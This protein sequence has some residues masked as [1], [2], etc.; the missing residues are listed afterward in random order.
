MG[1]V[2]CPDAILLRPTGCLHP[3]WSV[4]TVGCTTERIADHRL[5]S[6]L[7]RHGNRSG[8]CDLGSPTGN[9]HPRNKQTIG[10]RMVAAAAALVYGDRNIVY[11][12]PTATA[13]R[14]ITPPPA[15]SVRVE[16]AFVQESPLQA[17]PNRCPAELLGTS[18]C[19]WFQL[20]ASNGLLFNATA[21]IDG[22]SLVL[23]ATLP[24]GTQVM[25]A[26]YGWADWPVCTLYNAAG[27]PAPPFELNVPHLP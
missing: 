24:A 16:F 6:S 21:T 13:V 11:R 19:G 17:R 2:S 26:F 9:I 12:G 5:G 18:E 3:R 15:A 22:Q 4:R 8:S 25:H 20:Q 10:V 7:C 1:P 27:F 23:Q 14:V